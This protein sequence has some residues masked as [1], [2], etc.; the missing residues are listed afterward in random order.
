MTSATCFGTSS[1]GISGGFAPDGCGSGT[2]Q[3]AAR[4]FGGLMGR[5]LA[6]ELHERRA[7]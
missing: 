3:L 1:R 2:P 7:G 5:E 4:L 6:G